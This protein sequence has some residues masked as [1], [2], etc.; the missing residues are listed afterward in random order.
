MKRH[1][2]TLSALTAAA[3][4]AGSIR[5]ADAALMITLGT[6]G[7]TTVSVTDNGV[8]DN[9]PVVG[10]IGFTG[11]IGQ[12]STVI[13]AG[14]SNSPGANGLAILQTHTISVSNSSATAAVLTFTMGDTGFTTPAGAGLSLGSSFAGTFLSATPGAIVSFQSYADPSNAQFGKTVTSGLHSATQLTGSFAP[15]SFI[16]ADRSATFTSTGGYSLTDVTTISL[17]SNAQANVSGTTSVVAGGGAGTPEPAS[18]GILGMG[19][20]GLMGLRRR[21]LA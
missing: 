16:T 7:S 4:L 6:P 2:M 20:V 17:S 19:V 12:F 21:R 15:M 11:S 9:D 3:V 10:Q 1:W 14:T 18:L 13:T 8:G 5:S